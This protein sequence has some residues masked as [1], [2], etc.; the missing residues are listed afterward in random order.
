MSARRALPLLLALAGC[1]RFEVVEGNGV[2]RVERRTVNDFNEVEVS[3]GMHAVVSIG[4]KN[5]E[6]TIDA[7]ENLLPLIKLDVVD[8]RLVFGVDANGITPRDAPVVIQVQAE[9]LYFAGAAGPGSEISVVG[10]DT[11]ERLRLQA[12]LGSR[13]EASG[14]G[15]EMKLFLNEGSSADLRGFI[16]DKV[17]LDLRDASSAAVTATAEVTGTLRQ[18]SS[19]TVAGQPAT[20]AVE[21][22]DGSLITYE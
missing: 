16:A 3:S 4:S 18:G 17:E 12:V 20:R 21:L 6:I 2:R 5:S 19:A 15:K 13:L 10:V 1:P 11:A 8:N 9:K 7:D 14:K 22:L